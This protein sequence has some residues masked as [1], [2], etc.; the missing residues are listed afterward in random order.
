M[1][2]R[3]LLATDLLF[4]ASNRARQGPDVRALF[5]E[6]ALDKIMHRMLSKQRA[7]LACTLAA[8]V[9]LSSASAFAVAPPPEV[10]AK[11]SLFEAIDIVRGA[12]ARPIDESVDQLIDD[13]LSYGDY[14]PS[15]PLDWIMF[16]AL[17]FSS[18][19]APSS[20][21]ETFWVEQFPSITA[22]ERL[23]SF[24][25]VPAKKRSR[26]RISS[27][28]GP[29]YHPILKRWKLHN[30]VDFA[31]PTGTP[32]RAA[33][34]GIVRSAGWRGAAGKLVVIDHLDGHTSAYA[35]LSRI[36]DGLAAGDP[37]LAGSTLGEVGTT[38][39]STGP[40]LHF[41]VRRHGR[42][43]DPL[44]IEGFD[45]VAPI[46]ALEQELHHRRRVQPLL[47]TLGLASEDS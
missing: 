14:S 2:R 30:G 33:R 18:A 44:T 7:L 32:V 31:A 15:T 43:V 12:Q 46:E 25:S 23:F 38:G 35:H 47:A 16:T 20:S 3:I 41:V 26:V 22:P 29:R 13:A 36:R 40:H 6:R 21:A 17:K 37:I 11:P 39:R 4:D 27:H 19:F 8:L 42:P 24:V 34:S 1:A 45:Y 28:F 9:T 10:R 5:F